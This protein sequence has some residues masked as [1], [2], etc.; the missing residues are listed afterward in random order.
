LLSKY[1]SRRSFFKA[2]LIGSMTLLGSRSV[3]AK[4]VAGE[5]L[6]VGRLSLYNTHNGERLN[7]LYRDSAGRYDAGAI[8]ALDWIFRCS[9]TGKVAEM[10]LRT[11]EFLNQVDKQLGGGH[12][13]Q[14]ICGYRSPEY[15]TLL[16]HEGR[17]VSKNSLHL[18]AQAVDIAIHGVELS[19]VRHTALAM[20]RGGV[21]YYPESGFVHLDS[22]NIRSW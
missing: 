20:R 9:L 21:G 7:V 4:T 1:F 17:H 8:K 10:D 16:R 2:S 6:P 13:I 15:N 3:L 19:R 11:I 5:A 18:R 22:G 12:E 14:I